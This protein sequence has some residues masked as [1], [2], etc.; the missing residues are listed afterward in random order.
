MTHNGLINHITINYSRITG[1]NDTNSDE[2]TA[3]LGLLLINGVLHSS[4][5][6]VTLWVDD[7]IEVNI[8]WMTMPSSRVLF[9]RPGQIFLFP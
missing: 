4:H 8:F 3:F 5:L 2:M 9:L 6:N 7:G 1:I